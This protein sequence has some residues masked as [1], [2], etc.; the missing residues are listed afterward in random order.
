MKRIV[1]K[2]LEGYAVYNKCMPTSIE[3]FFS[4]SHDI[5]KEGMPENNKELCEKFIRENHPHADIKAVKAIL[6]YEIPED[7]TLC[8]QGEKCGEG[9][10]YC[11]DGMIVNA[12]VGK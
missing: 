1:H 6:Y 10:C 11:G 9:T 12:G 2:K 5:H 4:G 8:N 7:T 3:R